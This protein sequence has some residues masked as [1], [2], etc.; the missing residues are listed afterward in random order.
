MNVSNYAFIALSM[1]FI[2]R[3]FDM[4]YIGLKDSKLW[5]DEDTAKL[6]EMARTEWNMAC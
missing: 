2:V 5:E 6:W 1:N 3:S 4:P